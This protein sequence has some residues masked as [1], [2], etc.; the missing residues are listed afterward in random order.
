M[1]NLSIIFTLTFV[2]I[3]FVG[4]HEEQLGPVLD[5]GVAPGPVTNIEVENLHGAAVI[6][7]AVPSDPDLLY[8]K[9]SYITQDG[10]VRETKV[11]K[12]NRSISVVGFA[13]TSDYVVSLWAV[14]QGENQSEVQEVTVRPKRPNYL[15]ARDSLKAVSTF[16]GIIV[17]F[18]NQYQDD[19]AY[20]VITTDSLGNLSPINTYYSDA[21]SGNFDTRGLESEETEFGLYVRDRWGNISDTVFVSLTPLFEQRLDRSQMKGLTLP[22]DAPLGHRGVISGLFDGDLGNG[23]YYHSGDAAVMPQWFTFDMGTEAKLSRMKYFMRQGF[24][25]TLHNPRVM[26]IWGSNNPAPD[27]SFD[28]WILLASHTQIKPSG[29]G[30]GQLSQADTDAALE[31]ETITFPIDAPKVRYIRFKTLRNWSDGTYVNFNEIEMWGDP[32]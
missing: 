30:P 5:D 2:V 1:K 11:S 31:G 4:C 3:L 9:A 28:N 32:N 12:H 24:Y 23:S 22:T 27:G 14:D 21:K 29:L 6:S 19:L 16:G 18:K 8:I 25:F 7:Y 17:D 20:V 13:D 26:E 15:L 10:I